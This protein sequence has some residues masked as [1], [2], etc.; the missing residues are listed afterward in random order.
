MAHFLLHEVGLVPKELFITDNTP[1]RSQDA[2]CVDIAAI[3]EK[4]EIPVFFE[5]DAGRAQDMLRGIR[6]GGRGLGPGSGAEEG[7]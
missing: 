5:P 2:V 3:S 4:R 1:E 6:H 7:L